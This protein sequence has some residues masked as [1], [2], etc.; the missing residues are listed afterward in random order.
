[1]SSHQG[2]GLFWGLLLAGVLFIFFSIS[3]FPKTLLLLFLCVCRCVCI[4]W[5]IHHLAEEG[6]ACPE[7]GPSGRTLDL[8]SRNHDETSGGKE[9][10]EGQTRADEKAAERGDCLSLPPEMRRERWK[11]FDRYSN[12][13]GNFSVTSCRA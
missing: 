3:S 12:C 2:P 9:T 13:R 11:H 10:R 1:M 7:I 4:Q 5:A 6:A 8:E